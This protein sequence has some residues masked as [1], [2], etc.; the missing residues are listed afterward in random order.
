MP[1]PPRL[2][3][4]GELERPDHHYLPAGARC[5]FWGEY[6]PQRHVDGPVW[7]YSETNALI[8]NFKKKMDRQGKADWRY[9]GQ[10]IDTIAHAFSRF[11]KW[12]VAL[13]SLRL[14]DPIRL[15]AGETITQTALR[16][17]AEAL[18]RAACDLLE[19]EPGEV[20]A[21]YR[22]ALSQDGK[23]GYETEIFLYDT[24]PGGA[25]FAQAAAQAGRAIF[26]LALERMSACPEGTNC[27][28][29]CY[30]CLRTFR[31]RI[32]HSTLDRHTGRALLKF[33]LDDDSSGFDDR[34]LR[35][36]SRLLFD[37][38]DRQMPDGW[39][40]ISASLKP[41]EMP[42]GCVAPIEVVDA[43]GRRH[44]LVVRSP[45]EDLDSME[46]QK[47]DGTPWTSIQLV[48]ELTIRKNLPEATRQVLRDLA[49]LG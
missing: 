45:L 27:D 35:A 42:D 19:I 31:N 38:L 48:S 24:L 40:V 3:L 34:R 4:V 10:A 33:L 44:L 26:D 8:T 21:E 28:L 5:C 25:G 49:A 15:T 16:T 39:S 6:T 17:L 7:Q 12:P 29:S 2:T 36:A 41:A 20:Q 47:V 22:P 46:A 13:F 18:A 32:D 14:G 9:K 37:D 23:L 43:H 30:R 11:W 1:M